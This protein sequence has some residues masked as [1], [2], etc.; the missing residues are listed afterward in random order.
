MKI[1]ITD[2]ISKNFTDLDLE[3]MAF[4]VHLKEKMTKKT[5]TTKEE[6]SALSPR[7]CTVFAPL[8]RPK[9]CSNEE[10]IADTEA[11]FETK[12]NRSTKMVSKF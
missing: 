5:P 8:C 11:Y 3:S 6:K 12:I 7:Q 10:V 1:H 4:L 9:K 2:S